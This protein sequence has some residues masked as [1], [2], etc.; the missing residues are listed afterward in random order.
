MVQP[1]SCH[2]H[3]PDVMTHPKVE[4]TEK[5]NASVPT[6]C[7]ATPHDSRMVHLEGGEQEAALA[8]CSSCLEARDARCHALTAALHAGPL[9]PDRRQGWP[10][11]GG[12]TLEAAASIPVPKMLVGALMP[13]EQSSLMQCFVQL[14]AAGLPVVCMVCGGSSLL[15]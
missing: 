12:G 1:F 13:D 11:E 4:A 14:V 9:R 5:P 2:I 3:L 10:A 15:H 7:S 8:P 6:S